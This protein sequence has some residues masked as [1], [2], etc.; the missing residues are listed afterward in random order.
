[1]KQ[2]GWKWE[3]Q[4]PSPGWT[5]EMRTIYTGAT[6][7]EPCEL[8]VARDLYSG[9]VAGW[10]KWWEGSAQPD[11]WWVVNIQMAEEYYWILDRHWEI[12]WVQWLSYH[13]EIGNTLLDELE[14]TFECPKIGYIY[15]SFC[16]PWGAENI[17]YLLKKALKISWGLHIPLYEFL[18]EKYQSAIYSCSIYEKS[19]DQTKLK[20]GDIPLTWPQNLLLWWNLGV[21]FLQEISSSAWPLLSSFPSYKPRNW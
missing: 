16:F 20:E 9:A 7:S 17:Q 8:W 21:P 2:K 12:K 4:L 3:E 14:V 10:L 5:W 1:M 6:T 15:H 13:P 18:F 19:F 11:Y